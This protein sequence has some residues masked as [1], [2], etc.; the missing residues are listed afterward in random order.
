M[1]YK[2]NWNILS[3][4]DSKRLLT[5]ITGSALIIAASYIGYHMYY[6]SEE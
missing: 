1:D 2:I 5:N 3:Q 4:L 6:N